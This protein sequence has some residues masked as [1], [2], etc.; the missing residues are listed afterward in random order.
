MSSDSD[1]L[2]VFPLQKAITTD[3]LIVTPET[4]V[5]EAI[6]ILNQA[7]TF[8][9]LSLNSLEVSQGKTCL[10]VTEN[11]RPIGI[12]T[13]RDIVRLIAQRITLEGLT[14]AEVMT[15]PVITLEQ[16][17]FTNLSATLNLLNQHRIRHLPLVDIEGKLVGLLTHRDLRNSLEPT[18]LLKLRTIEEV[19]TSTVV[20][21]P[22][23]ISLLELTELMSSAHVSCVV[24][25]E[26]KIC[27]GDEL[28]FPVGLLTE[29][30][31]LKFQALGLSWNIEA[32]TVMSNPLCCLRPNDT[33]LSAHLLMQQR[34]IHRIPIVG[35][36]GE[37]IGIIT[38]TSILQA[39]NPIDLLQL[40]DVLQQKVTQLEAEK[41]Q[42]LQSQ[43]IKLEEKIQKRTEALKLANQRLQSEIQERSLIEAKIAFQASLL[44]QVRNAIIATDLNGKIIYWNQYAETLYQWK[45]K[46]A[47]GKNVIDFFVPLDYQNLAEEIVEEVIK[48]GYWEGEFTTS[49]KDGS[50]L[51]IHVFDTLIRD[52]AGNP[53]GLIGISFDITERKQAEQKLQQQ[54]QRERLFYQTAL[55]IRQSL[56][57]TDILNNA[58]VHIRS[59]LNCDRVVVYQFD[60]LFN[61]MIRAESVAEGWM[62]SL[63]IYLEDTCFKTGGVVHYLQGKKTV[64]YDLETADLTECH[65]QLL[66]QFEVKANLVVPIIIQPQDRETGNS[67][68]G[69]LIAHQCSAPRNWHS[70]ELELLD[71]IAVQLSLGIQQSLLYQTAQTELQERQKVEQKLRLLNQELETR[72]LDRTAKLERQ[73]RKSRLF[74]EIALKIRQSLDINQILQTTVTEVQKILDCDRLLIYR[75]FSNG[76]GRA[77]AESVLPGWRSILNVNFPEE[78]FPPEYQQ[79]YRHGTVKAIADIDQTYQEV[80]PCLVE[81]LQ[82]WRVKAKLVVPILQNDYFWGFM[83][84]HHCTCPRQWTEFEIELMREIADQ[85]GVALEQAQLVE[86]IRERE[87]F[88]ERIADNSPNILYIYDLAQNR[89]IYSSQSL[90]PILGYTTLEISE[91]GDDFLTIF[92]PDDQETVRQHLQQTAQLKDRETDYIEYR[93]QH[94][95]GEWL[96]FSSHGTVFKRDQQGNTQQILGV[97]QNITDRKQAEL[98]LYQSH[99][100]L[101]AISYAQ[102]QF[103]TDGDSHLLFENLLSS[104]LKLTESQYAF[105]G[106][107]FSRQNGEAYLEEYYMKKQGNP[108][109]EIHP[110]THRVCHLE[111]DPGK[112]EKQAQ[113]FNIKGLFCTVILAGK[114]VVINSHPINSIST[115]NLPQDYLSFTAFLGIPFYT[116]KELLG[117]VCVANRPGGYDQ[118]LINYLQPFLATCSN[119]IE[120]DRIERLHQKVED[121]LKRQL[122]AVEAS[123][124]GISI[125]KNEEYIYVNNSHLKLFGYSHPD[126]LLG[127]SWRVLYTPDVVEWF[128]ENVF[129]LLTQQK[130]WRGETI[131]LR[132][133]GT[134]FNQEVSLTV[135]EDGDY[136]CVF[137]DISERQAA[138]RERKNAENQL[139]Q[140]NEQLAIANAQLARASRLKDEFLANMSHELRTPLNSILGM[141]EVLQEG[142]F[143]E[144]TDQQN[145]ALAMIHRNGK[146]LLELIN[147]ILDLSKIEAGKFDLERSPVSV[148]ELCQNSLSFV[149]QQ[150][151]QKNIRLSYQIEDVTEAL[152]V[153][154]RRMR[155]VLINLLNNAVKFT[156]EGGRVRLEVR[157]DLQEQ[158]ISFSVIDNGIGITPEDQ[159]RLFQAFI[160]IDSRLSRRYEGTGL[161]LVLVK[162]LVEMHGGTV[163]IDS[164]LGKGSCFT[165][166]LPWT[167]LSWGEYPILTPTEL[168]DKSPASRSAS[169]GL[170]RPLILL[171]EDNSDNIHTLLNYLQAK[172]FDVEVARNGIEAVQKARD[173]HPQVILMDIS[174]PEMDGLEATRQIRADPQLATLPII[175]L[176][177]LAMQGDR[178]QCLAAGVNEYLPKPV[179]LRQ[180]I[181]L[182]QSLILEKKAKE[183]VNEQK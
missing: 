28:K 87:Q 85:V 93:I 77:I 18:D 131:A 159:S 109:L 116:H 98:D 31:I 35:D 163:K 90:T 75:V 72:I 23:T 146:H 7:Q 80:T 117:V 53:M 125:L 95:N 136:I 122:A 57:L 65:K 108:Y 47:V 44:D 97:A 171:A 145:Q 164:Q 30:D 96:W 78:V 156:P 56:N 88:I 89:T 128:E 115:E 60:P 39:I 14:V 106:E 182:I 170:K 139:R 172:G 167:P 40:V 4:P 179:Q 123:I 34:H 155:Q 169:K 110:M 148:N 79:L 3:P 25:V 103:I 149:K 178:E 74:A 64:I 152:N 141:S 82:E 73:E 19:M 70:T 137:Q 86:T 144:L 154:E 138:L 83:I 43:N 36:Q 151:H 22:A 157:G 183:L 46:E 37:L 42:L 69:L 124:D 66:N 177:A 10:I 111:L 2:L 161:G 92:H 119:I 133:D 20:Q 9:S 45:A 21:A 13:H 165:L 102:A 175:A 49:R 120:A 101:E 84:A 71:E 166:T 24:L 61:G 130:F 32:Q 143:G 114:P 168:L 11:N 181:Q 15:Q 158:T 142:T 126:E 27:N 55:H 94:R 67:L 33:L 54:V 48:K 147:D 100:I 76:T 112:G 174:M 1:T 16:T 140:T 180:L 50:T 8:C 12:L 121:N 52:Q 113:N 104:V 162:K 135:T 127:K 38:P 99:Q 29:G 17:E 59:I 81:F 91:M 105:M 173:L 63:G 129:P 41:L 26:E 160:Q 62:S 107:V 118:N 176:T 132:K 150:A 153:D 5:I 58:V 51:P 134:T 6:A 68:W